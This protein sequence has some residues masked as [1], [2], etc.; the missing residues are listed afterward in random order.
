MLV[1]PAMFFMSVYQT[2][3]ASA[4][5]FPPRWLGSG[6]APPLA[7]RTTVPEDLVPDNHWFVVV[8]IVDGAAFTW[9]TR[10]RI[11]RRRGVRG[12]VLYRRGEGGLQLWPRWARRLD[13]A[14][15]EPRLF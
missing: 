14:S 8:G 15:G 2:W 7:Y 12:R 6:E 9:C 5:T 10:A 11:A 13:V 3:A 4:A 1:A